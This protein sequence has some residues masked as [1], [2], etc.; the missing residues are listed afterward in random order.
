MLPIR[1]KPWPKAVS[2]GKHELVKVI[3]SELAKCDSVINAGDPD[4]EGQ[5]IV[6][7]VLDWLKYKGR[8][9]RVYISDS[10]DKNIKKA[11]SK[12]KDNN[13]CRKD[14]DSALARQIADFAF[15][16]NESRLA[17]LKTGQRVSVGRV[18]TPTLGLIVNRDRAIENHTTEDFYELIGNYTVDNEK[19]VPF[20]FIPDEE[21]LDDDKYIKTKSK[22]EEIEKKLPEEFS[23]NLDKKTKKES[24][25]LP[26]NLTV[27]QSE[28][29]KRYGYSAK[30][31]L[32]ITQDLRDKYKA[33]T[34]NR[35][36]CQYL[37]SEH[38]KEAK[39]VAFLVMKN[40]GE[41]GK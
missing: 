33:I 35:T 14:G 18:Q 2:K 31:T 3:K 32:N 5:L 28:M 40:L 38:Y 24:A 26:F 30:E 13:D 36:D 19:I 17:G 9:E 10:V 22:L 39:D 16:I 1:L 7:E 23:I 12:L 27:L 34:Y 4:D 29:S 6:D 37:S 25:P 8:V 11:F 15:G 20:K 41:E 21:L